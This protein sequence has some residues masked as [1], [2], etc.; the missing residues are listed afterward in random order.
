MR[1]RLAFTKRCR[2]GETKITVQTMRPEL[3][4]RVVNL[5]STLVDIYPV[6][7]GTAMVDA[8]VWSVQI[9]GVPV[10]MSEAYPLE[11]PLRW[12]VDLRDAS[13]AIAGPLPLPA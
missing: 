10:N 9:S 13:V 5:T 6:W 8:S 7:D 3:G 11:G 1:A 2:L 4:P 12:A